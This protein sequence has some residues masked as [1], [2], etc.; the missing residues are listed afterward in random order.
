MK[1]IIKFG[2]IIL[3]LIFVVTPSYASVVS[4]TPQCTM[5]ID[6]ESK[7]L[8]RMIGQI[9]NVKSTSFFPDSF[10]KTFEQ[11]KIMIT[12]SNR[13]NKARL[14]GVTVLKLGVQQFSS[15]GSDGAVLG[16]HWNIM[17]MEIGE[18]TVDAL[19]YPWLNFRLLE[20]AE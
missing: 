9:T 1:N 20:E 11:K 2:S 6:I 15:N 10:C 19:N 12:G 4:E 18:Y 3:C 8:N 16:L 7:D 13:L 17:H 14:N 5:D